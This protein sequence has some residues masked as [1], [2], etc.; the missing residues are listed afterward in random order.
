[1][2][3]VVNSIKNWWGYESPKERR[4]S[5][6]NQWGR[7][8]DNGDKTCAVILL[9]FFIALFILCFTA[10]AQITTQP[11]TAKPGQATVAK[12]MGSMV[13]PKT[14]AQ[15]KEFVQWQQLYGFTEHSHIY[16][17]LAVLLSIADQHGTI[18]NR[19]RGYISVILEANDPNSLVSVVMANHNAIELLVKENEKLTKQ[20]EELKAEQTTD[21]NKISIDD[22][23]NKWNSMAKPA[24]TGADPN[25]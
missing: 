15:K 1:M 6:R 5:D 19:N 12:S 11:R 8:M 10:K 13:L 17:N 23:L 25:N 7:P 20:I 2:K 3:K 4:Q 24:E 21:P 22:V 16:Y 9:S 14:E 18:I